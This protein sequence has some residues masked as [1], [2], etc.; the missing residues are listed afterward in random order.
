MTNIRSISLTTVWRS[1]STLEDELA[2]SSLCDQKARSEHT[3][4]LRSPEITKSMMKAK[5]KDVRKLMIKVE[6]DIS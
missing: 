5:V 6:P 1:E 3:K 4:D 2:L